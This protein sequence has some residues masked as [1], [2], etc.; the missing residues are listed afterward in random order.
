MYLYIYI[1]VYVY[2]YMYI[3][4]YICIYLCIDTTLVGM[5]YEWLIHMYDIYIHI[6]IYIHMYIYI[7]IYMYTYEC[8]YMYIYIY[9]YICKHLCIHM[10]TFM[11]KFNSRQN[12]VRNSFI[13][14]TSPLYVTW[15][16]ASVMSHSYVRHDSFT[17][18]TW[19]THMCDMSLWRVCHEL[20]M[21]F[22]LLS[23]SVSW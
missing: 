17:R 4:I 20:F 6:Y 1:Y 12:G 13:C 16:A 10:Y 11:Y 22:I 8:M 23:F 15:L 18:V 2:I 7:Y 5:E 19:L 14:V 3:Y 9:I 21:Y